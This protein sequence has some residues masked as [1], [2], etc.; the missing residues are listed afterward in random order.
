[1][2]QNKKIILLTS[3]SIR[4]M[5]IAHSL[6]NKFDLQLIVTEEKS[7]RIT[8]T[9]GL[10]EQDRKLI[11]SH[12]KAREDTEQLY[13]NDYKSFPKGIKHLSLEYNMINHVDTYNLIASLKPDAIILFG[14]SIIKDPLLGVFDGQIINLHLGL[15]PYYKGSGTNL[16]P[17][18][19]DEP[20][21]VGATIHLAVKKVDAGAIL[22]QY[23]PDLTVKDNIHDIGNKVIL[24][25]GEI[26][27]QVVDK[28]LNGSIKPVPQ[29][30]SGGKILKV[31]DFTPD[32]LRETIHKLQKGM[33]SEYIKKKHVL[34][35]QK[36][37]IEAV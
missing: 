12:F 23:R 35:A 16:W 6:S 28:Y 17:L 27:P 19:Y 26:L 33:M 1:M 13:F 5:F 37:I 8:S 21:C 22:H 36:P 31:A 24:K 10:S 29:S 11:D 2:A 34:D 4:H 9:D 18:Y 25:G 32:I 20:E 15:S 3:T 30:K 14:T 7:P